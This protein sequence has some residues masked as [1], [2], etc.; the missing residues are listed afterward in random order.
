MYVVGAGQTVE[1]KEVLNGSRPEGRSCDGAARAWNKEISLNKWPN[2]T[3]KKM[4]RRVLSLDGD[5]PGIEQS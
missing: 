4:T 2:F 5:A 3:S 1:T